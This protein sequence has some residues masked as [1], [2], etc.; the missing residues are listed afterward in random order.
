VLVQQKEY[1]Q[2]SSTLITDIEYFFDNNSN[3][4]NST[5][6]NISQN[7]NQFEIATDIEVSELDSG[8]HRIY[9]RAK[10]ANGNWGIVQSKP[11]LVDSNDYLSPKITSV[12]YFFD[13]DPGTAEGINLNFPLE[14]SIEIST[15][16]ALDDLTLGQHQV[17]IRALDENGFWS[18]PQYRNFEA[19]A[20]AMGDV[21]H[22]NTIDLSDLILVLKL[23]A[24]IDANIYNEDANG[25]LKIGTE[26]SI[27]IL[28]TISQ[29]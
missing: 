23:L 22:N 26:E 7:S 17:Y 28:Q 12:E 15:Y 25:D 8:L 2:S 16:L 21:D 20:F 3:I 19:R 27:Y 18:V 24:G 6:L 11:F 4:G 1:E 9:L 10:D 13:T 5:P 14:K 29:K